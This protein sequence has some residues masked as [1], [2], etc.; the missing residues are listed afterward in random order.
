MKKI[1]TLLM[2]ALTMTAFLSCDNRWY[3]NPADRSDRTEAYV[4]EGTWT[5]YVDTYM[6]DRFGLRGN[7]Y[8]TTMYF[9]RHDNYGG[10]G[11]EVD[12]NLN[13][14][15]DNY[16]Y[17]E[18]EWEVYG[19]EIL[20]NYADSWNTV[21][22]YDYR[23]TDNR[24]TGYMDDGTARDILFELYYDSR[25][26]WS[27]YRTYYAPAATRSADSPRFHAKGVFALRP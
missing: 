12:Y 13:S 22:I 27:F 21:A 8:R 20:I 18:F 19:G 17:C 1:Y 7:N 14:P 11:Y 16:Y 15:R 6:Y 10:Y 3:D 24:F 5:G 23:L 2:M 26:D 4:L 25:F 9:E